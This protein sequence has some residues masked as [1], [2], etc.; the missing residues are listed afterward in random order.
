VQ[1]AQSKGSENNGV[2]VCGC[3]RIYVRH[4]PYLRCTFTATH[5]FFALGS[6]IS[7]TGPRYEECIK[8]RKG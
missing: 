5:Q 6:E 2:S 1:V 7:Y 4:V 3:V 8:R